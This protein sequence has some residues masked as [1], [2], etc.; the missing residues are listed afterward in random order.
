M[1]LKIVIKLALPVFKVGLLQYLHSQIKFT[2]GE[3]IE[4]KEAVKRLLFSFLIFIS[5]F[6]TIRSL[7]T[8][9]FRFPSTLMNLFFLVSLIA[10]FTLWVREYKELIKKNLMLFP[11]MKK[12]MVE[13]SIVMESMENQGSRM[14]HLYPF[15]FDFPNPAQ[16]GSITP[17]VF[18]EQKTPKMVLELN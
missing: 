10:I 5:I 2:K 3:K 4:E 9:F 16:E 6:S 13:H 7:L 14:N 15:L 17:P 12:L 8:Y 18:N 1:Y 11:L